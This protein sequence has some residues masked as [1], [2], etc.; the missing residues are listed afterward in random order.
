MWI[1]L[2]QNLGLHG[3]RLGTDGPSNETAQQMIQKVMIW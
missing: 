3:E 2:G 1:G